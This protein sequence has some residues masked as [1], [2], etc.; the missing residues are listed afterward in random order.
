MP[1]L[2]QQYWRFLK[3]R[4]AALPWQRPVLRWYWS[5]GL[6]DVE[7]LLWHRF[8]RARRI[9]DYGAGDLRLKQKF[10]A[11]GFDGAYETF[12]LSAESAHTYRDAA[13]IAG[14]YDAVFL[15][16]VIEHMPLEAF[17]EL[18]DQVTGWLAPGAA[19]V[20]ETSNPL[21]IVPMWSRDVTHIQQY[22]AADLCA[23]LALRGF[24]IDAV[25]RLM[26]TPERVGPLRSLRFACKKFL[27]FLLDVDY[28][29]SVLVIAARSPSGTPT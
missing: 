28:A 21:C 18:L 17:L 5:K 9:L 26:V 10:L 6:N 22:P 4:D 23:I 29:D 24:A 20:I 16:E 7:R 19:L 13:A 15:L 25:H 27:T 12:D 1:N 3:Q 14:P 8:H 2:F 11:Q